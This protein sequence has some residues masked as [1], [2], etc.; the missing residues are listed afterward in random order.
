MYDA[1]GTEIKL[2]E[3]YAV[4]ERCKGGLV[5]VNIGKVVALTPA[6][7]ITLLVDTGILHRAD[8][9]VSRIE[10]Q[11]PLRYSVLPGMLFKV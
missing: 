1:L 4:S 10:C 6:G 3:R 5:T 9:E 2:G 7:K 11:E 8:G